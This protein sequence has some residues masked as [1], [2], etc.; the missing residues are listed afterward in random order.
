[1]LFFSIGSLL[2]AVC[3]AAT[4]ARP[5]PMDFTDIE[6]RWY[7]GQSEVCKQV[8]G[9]M[10]PCYVFIWVQSLMRRAVYLPPMRSEAIHEALN[11]ASGGV[12]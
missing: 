3:I 9:T 8:V 10:A 2:L 7:E 4:H 1:M 5:T 11:D 6:R 12:L